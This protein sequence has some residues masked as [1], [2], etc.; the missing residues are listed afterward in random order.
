MSGQR[1]YFGRDLQVTEELADGIDLEGRAR[2][3]WYFIL[4]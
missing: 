1:M 3:G 4:G 2:R